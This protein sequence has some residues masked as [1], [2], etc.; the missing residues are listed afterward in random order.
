MAFLLPY[1]CQD[2]VEVLLGLLDVWRFP[3][4]Q[5]FTG[6]ATVARFVLVG[7]AH[8]ND[9]QLLEILLET[10]LPA[11]VEHL[12]KTLFGFVNTVFG[13]AFLLRNP[14]RGVAGGDAQTYIFRE[15]LG[16]QVHLAGADA[17]DD[18]NHPVGLHQVLHK[19]VGKKVASYAQLGER[20]P[21]LVHAV[22]DQCR[23]KY[24]V[25]VIGNSEELALDLCQIGHSG[26]SEAF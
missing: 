1:A 2:T 20:K 19:L 7:Y 15:R 6:L 11:H 8:G 17:A 23:V 24:D 5:Q 13:A 25:P 4:E 18:F 14:D 9:V 22:K 3:A 21:R 26:I 10:I 12:Q 16:I